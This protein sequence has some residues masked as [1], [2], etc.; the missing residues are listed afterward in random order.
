MSIGGRILRVLFVIFFSASTAYGLR[1]VVSF[2]YEDQKF[3]EL[4]NGLDRDK[5][6]SN[7]QD[8]FKYAS[9]LYDEAEREPDLPLKLKFLCRSLS[10]IGAALKRD[11]FNSRMLV[12]WASLRQLLGRFQCEEIFTTGDFE[13]VLRLGIES[14][15]SDPLVLFEAAK[16]L[17]WAGKKSELLSVLRSVLQFD[18]FLSRE[19][20][21][22]VLSIMQEPEDLKH[23]LPPRFPQVAKWASLIFSRAL[24]RDS[25]FFDTLYGIQEEALLTTSE[26]FDLGKIPYFVQAE[27]LASLYRLPMLGERLRQILDRL[28][29][30]LLEHRSSTE[31]AGYLKERAQKRELEVLR[32]SI[33]GDTR[34]VK[35]SMSQWGFSHR[36]CLD[37][38]G[39]SSGFYLPH[40]QRV[41]M[42]ELHFKKA[43]DSAIKTQF[44][45]YV[46]D[47][48]QQW[49]EEA[50]E[51][52]V[53]NIG[54]LGIHVLS[55]KF[56]GISRKY[57]KFKY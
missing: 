28:S 48:N 7:S 37:K 10:E 36:Q 30:A 17:N 27:R 25:E 49:K 5:S 14:D 1:F 45:L 18:I 51:S 16:V 3:I 56:P 2:F 15:R 31:G 39:F 38:G 9:R 54:D 13:E 43:I 52:Q 46:S 4:T 53:V 50:I 23:V 24:Q 44:K 26:E 22:F 8:K 29:G 21:E 12:S 42:V 47:D 32:G 41:S 34:Q 19:E 40:Q 6:Q 57:W 33:L 20:E 11:P 35:S 55:L